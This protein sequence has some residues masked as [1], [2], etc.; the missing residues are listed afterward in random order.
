MKRISLI[1][2][3]CS[4]FFLTVALQAG[5]LA[6]V[7]DGASIKLYPDGSYQITAVGTGTYD[8]NDPDDVRE[9]RRDAE[10]RAKSTIAKFLKEDIATQESMA[11]A[12]RKI[13]S[14]SAEGDEVQTS[15]SKESVKETMEAIRTSASALLTG[16]IVLQDER[17]PE[18]NGGYYRVMV[19][20]SS[21]TIAV[22]QKATAGMTSSSSASS[23][24]E[25]AS[26]S[27][28]VLEATSTAMC[29]D[30]PPLPEGWIQC[31]GY[32]DERKA[33]IQQALVE[34]I[35][36]VYGQSLVNDERMSERMA[37]FKAM[38]RTEDG[39]STAVGKASVK[40][41]ESTTLTS[42]AG[43]VREYRIIS[44]LP[45]DGNMEAIVYAYIVNPRAGGTIALKVKAATMNPAIAT[46][47]FD[48]GPKVK[49]SGIEIGNML[50]S[51]LPSRLARQ[52]K[53]IIINDASQATAEANKAETEDMVA[54]GMASASELNM[55]G[56][57]L[58]PDY[59]MDTEVTEIKYSK[60]MGMDKVSKKFAPF[61]KM[62]VK[63]KV[64]LTNSRTGVIIRSDAML[65]SLSSEQI[66][67]ILSE[68][69]EANL[70]EFVL[71][72]FSDAIEEWLRESK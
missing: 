33:A 48:L 56:Q 32:G 22:T 27:S 31:I 64:T 37:K 24:E 34:G 60:K 68:D 69:E 51:S 3:F 6:D 71:G 17:V 40:T 18:G 62:S 61:Y 16:V 38:T 42:T 26:S 49:M 67:E 45:K 43:F 50:C 8:F 21:K 7:P 52:N 35:S 44:V 20:V 65:L 11:E 5:P 1:L 9:A 30:L 25:T 39:E 59:V 2:L 55:L 72:G 29:S 57:G 14:V 70:L 54:A 63:L 36:Q 28:T 13:K 41:S 12:S 15:V 10:M 58:T 53:F 66:A 19:G 47:V 46:T 23:S 4:V